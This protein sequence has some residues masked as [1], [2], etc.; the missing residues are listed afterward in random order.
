VVNIEAMLG[1][2]SNLPGSCSQEEWRLL[3][4]SA[5][6]AV[7]GFSHGNVVEVGSYCGR[8]TTALGCAVRNAGRGKV[9]AIHPR[10]A[11]LLGV[12]YPWTGKSRR[13]IFRHNLDILKLNEWVTTIERKPIE[14]A[15]TSPVCFLVIGRLIDMASLSEDFSHFFDRVEKGGYVAFHDYGNPNLPN[16]NS[17]VEDLLSQGKL[18][19]VKTES[20][21][22][23]TEKK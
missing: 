18:S 22:I 7:S 15:W 17:F 3:Y 2:V 19:K 14:V 11:G 4:A 5:M 6:E 21:L 13:R 16:V 9:Y 10:E 8:V 1:Y 20:H 23:V 12:P